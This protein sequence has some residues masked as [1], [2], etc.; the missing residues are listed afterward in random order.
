M[1][2]EMVEGVVKDSRNQEEMKN[3]VED[4]RLRK[5]PAEKDKIKEMFPKLMFPQMKHYLN[6][7]LNLLIYGVGSKRGMVNFFV[8]KH[9]TNDPR[10][11][12][13]GFHSATSMK[14]ITNPT[15][16]F[17]VKHLNADKKKARGNMTTHDQVD[18]IK[19]IFGK[20]K[21]GELNFSKY[22]IVIHSMDCGNLKSHE[23]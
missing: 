17:A 22:H 18:E 20:V 2:K 15:L 8:Q 16:N 13:N 12:V 14:S 19:R 9:L 7:G 5:H 3:E 11:I 1:D 4:E 6:C 21:F 10:L 23:D